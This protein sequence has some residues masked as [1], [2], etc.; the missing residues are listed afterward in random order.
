MPATKE[1]KKENSNKIKDFAPVAGKN[2]SNKLRNFPRNSLEEIFAKLQPLVY[3]IEKNQMANIL[4]ELKTGKELNSEQF[5]FINN[6]YD[7][8]MEELLPE[9]AQEEYNNWIVPL[10]I[11]FILVGIICRVSSNKDPSIAL[12]FVAG[13]NLLA[14]ALTVFVADSLVVKT[15]KEW[16][17]NSSVLE[18]DKRRL[19]R[20]FLMHHRKALFFACAIVALAAIFELIMW[21]AQLLEIGNDVVSILAFGLAFCSEYVENIMIRE[22]ESFIKENV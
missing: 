17:E 20:T 14:I 3:E 13:I 12:V 7:S 1:S 21:F 2:N 22:Y 9:L 6:C 18:Y 16:V 19:K 8:H 4:S 5:T 11:A 15:V 10:T